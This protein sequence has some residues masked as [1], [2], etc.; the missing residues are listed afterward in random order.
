MK[1]EFIGNANGQLNEDSFIYITKGEILKAYNENKAKA[2]NELNGIIEMFTTPA[3]FCGQLT[4]EAFEKICQV[5]L[6]RTIYKGIILSY[7][8]NHEGREYLQISLCH[9]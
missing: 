6:Q 7:G 1:L 8:E 2:F 9:K 5:H 4:P 3:C